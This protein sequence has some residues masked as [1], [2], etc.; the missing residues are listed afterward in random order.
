MRGWLALVAEHRERCATTPF[1]AEIGGVR[2]CVRLGCYVNAPLTCVRV[3]FAIPVS[4]RSTGSGGDSVTGPTAGGDDEV[5]GGC[6]GDA[7]TRSD[8]LGERSAL[9][10]CVPCGNE[11]SS[12]IDG[13]ADV[14]GR[15]RYG[16]A[17]NQVRV[18]GDTSGDTSS[19]RRSCCRGDATGERLDIRLVVAVE[20]IPCGGEQ[21]RRPVGG[22]SLQQLESSNDDTITVG[23]WHRTQPASTVSDSWCR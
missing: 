3:C 22:A 13:D 5:N 21:Q 2:R 15:D 11:R 18:K 9:R 16:W 23:E 14:G 6:V 17:S 19:F 7:T 4:D 10:Q 20:V 8:R 12:R 1:M